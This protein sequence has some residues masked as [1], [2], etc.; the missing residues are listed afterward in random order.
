MNIILIFLIAVSLSMDAFSL[1]LAYG[2]NLLVNK[3]IKILTLIVGLYHFIM[4]ILGMLV[5]NFIIQTIHID[6]KI[7]TLI[8]FTF[9]GINMIIET[10]SKNEKV[11]IM[12]LGEMFLF[13]FAVSIDSFSIGIGIKS[14]SNNFLLCSALFSLTS[15]LFTYVGLKLGNRLNLLLGKIATLLGGIMLIV[16]GIIYAI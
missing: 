6:G 4:P 3:E 9:I 1:S 15:A 10:Y 5:G 13:G 12:K 2:T 16:L 7:I 14:I 8:I 11:K